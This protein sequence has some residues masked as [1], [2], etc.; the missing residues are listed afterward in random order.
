MLPLL[1]ALAAC[2]GR[3]THGPDETPG[4][5]RMFYGTDRSQ[6]DVSDPRKH[7]GNT[8]G[9][10]EYGIAEAV[11]P[12]RSDS[13]R[14]SA[15]QPLPRERFLASLRS[16]VQASKQPTVVVY[17]H[18]FSRSFA[19]AGERLAEFNRV[20]GFAGVPV[21]WSWPS[22]NSPTGYL[23]DETNVRWSEPDFARFVRDVLHH[24]GAETVHLVG[25]SLGGR[26]L[27]E[28]MLHRLV[29]AGEDLARV[30]EFVLL[31]PD[32]DAAIFRRDH[33]P[34]L[35]QA[36]LRVTLYTADN[37]RAMQSAFTIRNYPRAG[38]S[39]YGPLTVDGIDTIDVSAANRSVLGHAYFEKNDVVAHEIAA[40]LNTRVRA[41]ARPG[42]TR[43]DTPTGTYW[44]LD[45]GD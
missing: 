28:M 16:A 4:P 38:D 30:G 40:L 2:A 21:I 1:L 8:R 37:D 5:L 33:A 10:L 34:A 13:G 15:V 12:E 3:P 22:S 43:V 11:H 25:H 32:I 45:G 14:L 9:Q 23:Q 19:E 35:V 20:S 18:G 44:R 27:V 39:R 36:G 7:Y 17:V 41:A 24:S 31:A 42:L 29:P 6:R 26:A